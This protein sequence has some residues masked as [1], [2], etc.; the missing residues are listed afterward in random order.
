M[1]TIPAIGLFALAIVF[2]GCP[3]GVWLRPD[4]TP[5]PERCSEEAKRA[6]ELL[7]LHVG[8]AAHVELDAN[9]SRSSP[10]TLYDGP[11]ESVLWE[12]FGTLEAPSRLYGRVWTAGP[13]VVIRYYEAQR[14]D[15]QP[16][17]ICAVARL[18]ENQL[19]KLPGS[20]P[21]MAI[22]EFSGASA[23]V[24]SEFR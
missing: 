9:Q 16:V 1:R 18:S 2:S 21:G 11:I 20:K 23:F 10:I 12:D 4:G 14:P 8:D 17:P 24:V 19:R 3:T 5:G 15:G 22:L 13:Q 7:R 6:M